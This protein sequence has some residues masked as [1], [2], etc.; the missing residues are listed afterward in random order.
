MG[1]MKK[2]S[3]IL[4]LGG[5]IIGCALAES[6]SRSGLKVTLLE[7]GLIGREASW[8]AAGMLA[9][10]SEMESPGA[11]LDF[12][13]ASRRLY[14]DVAERL[15]A[16]TLIDPQ[17]RTE[18]MFYAAFNEAESGRI[19]DRA[20][21]QEPLGLGVETLTPELTRSREPELSESVSCVVHFKEDH[22]LDPRLMTQAYAAAARQL[23]AQLLEYS[24]VAS[25]LMDGGRVTGAECVGERY[26]AGLTILA[27]GAWSGLLPGVLPGIPTYPVKGEVLLLQ[28]A[29]GLFR[30]TLHSSSI[31]LVPRYDGRVVVGATE[32]HEAGYD[33]IVRTD[34]VRLLLDRAVE[35]VPKLGEAAFVDAWAG[36]RPGTP[37]RRPI[38]G[39]AG[40]DGLLLC[41]GHFRNGILLAP[42][43]AKLFAEYVASGKPP[44]EIAPFGIE[45]FETAKRVAA[46][47]RD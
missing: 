5:G 39:P 27:A 10:Q 45:R 28:A 7:R 12:C 9:P 26:S 17:Y 14:P 46:E 32:D 36:L 18:G 41:T 11:Y 44:V 24:P 1:A 47:R 13:L 43:T 37:D 42:L 23:G 33:K 25:L 16:E 29:P 38:L 15:A 4:I 34:A 19:L 22:Q 35:L 21:W 2:T 8:A 20:A 40:P 31:Y 30:H 6:L 3:D